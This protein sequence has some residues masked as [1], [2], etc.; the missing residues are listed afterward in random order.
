MRVLIVD[1][2]RAMRMIV[3]RTLRQHG[4][5]VDAVV[6][7]DDG[8]SALAALTD[9]APDLI[10]ADWDLPTMSGLELLH[11]VRAAGSSAVFGFITAETRV[12][13]REQAIAAGAAFVAAKPIDGERLVELV[14]TLVH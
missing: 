7:A 5:V 2:S 9:L 13:L 10:L 8:D 4:V 12:T 6:E 3:L 11:A 1:D 14:G